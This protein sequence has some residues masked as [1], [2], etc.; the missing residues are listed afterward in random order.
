MIWLVEGERE[1]RM[2]GEIRWNETLMIPLGKLGHGQDQRSGQT[3]I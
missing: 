1:R 2:G 3:G